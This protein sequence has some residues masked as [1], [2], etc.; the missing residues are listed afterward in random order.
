[1]H[2]LQTNDQPKC[3]VSLS[4]CMKMVNCARSP[5]RHD[6]YTLKKEAK[7]SVSFATYD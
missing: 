2:Q 5:L 3:S 6:P 7:A 4:Q 1:M